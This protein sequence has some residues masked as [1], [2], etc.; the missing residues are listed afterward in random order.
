MGYTTI[1][2][3]KALKSPGKWEINEIFKLNGDASMKK[4][5]KTE[6][7]GDIYL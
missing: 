6:K 2:L 4:K 3:L 7:F 1:D 5:Y